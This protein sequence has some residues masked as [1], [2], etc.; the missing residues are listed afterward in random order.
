M[1]SL[2]KRP[3]NAKKNGNFECHWNDIL[4]GWGKIF[5]VSQV[6]KFAQAFFWS[7]TLIRFSFKIN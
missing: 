5:G 1:Y 2:S 4:W 6:Q 3:W 7:R